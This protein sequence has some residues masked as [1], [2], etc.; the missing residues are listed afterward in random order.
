MIRLDRFPPIQA[1]SAAPQASHNQDR[2]REPTCP[3]G[4][5]MAITPTGPVP[6]HMVTIPHHAR[7]RRRR[8]LAWLEPIWADGGCN[9]WQVEAAVAKVPPLRMEIV[10][11][12]DAM[13]GFVVLPRR[14]GG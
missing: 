1:Q 7:S 3:D 8:H 14:W 5:P 9:A 13:N 4:M 2:Y 11:R 10:R 6:I 12:S